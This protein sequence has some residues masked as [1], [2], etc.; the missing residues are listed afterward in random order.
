MA[1]R[2]EEKFRAVQQENKITLKESKEGNDNSTGDNE[3]VIDR[4][5]GE[6]IDISVLKLQEE[7][8]DK[9]EPLF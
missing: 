8:S 7:S 9:E 3:D 1:K 6:E 2:I 5:N 4:G